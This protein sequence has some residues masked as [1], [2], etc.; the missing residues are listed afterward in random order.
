MTRRHLLEAA[1]IVFAR[2][3]FHGARLDDVAAPAGLHQGRGLLQLQSKDDLFL[4]LLDDR[5]D[6]QFAV[7]AE[8]LDLG[9]HDRASRVSA[10]AR[11]PSIDT[12]RRGHLR[13]ALPRVRAL[14]VP[15]SGREKLIV[16]AWRERDLIESLI[17]REQGNVNAAAPYSTSV[18][19][20]FSRWYSTGSRSHGSSTRKQSPRPRSTPHSTCSTKRWAP[21]RATI[22]IPE[23]AQASLTTDRPTVRRCSIASSA[24]GRSRERDVLADDGAE[25]ARREQAPAARRAAARR[26]GAPGS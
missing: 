9:P 21:T 5:V 24:A 25:L 15:E 13:R 1:A 8:V 20:E 17:T 16:S 19:A 6:R 22:R 3:G 4:A 23:G 14:R 2:D 26:R 18:L 11:P 10:R 12:L 7:T